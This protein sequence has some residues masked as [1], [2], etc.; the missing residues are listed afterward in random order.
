MAF[1][2]KP[3]SAPVGAIISDLDVANMSR[4][5]EADLYRAFLDWGVLVFQ[6]M[7][8]DVPEHVRLANLFGEMDDPHP[9]PDL[10]HPEVP[11]MSVLTANG[12]AAVAP[13]DPDA[14]ML[15]GTI[16]WHADRM[17]T[18]RPNR[19]SLLR[20]VVIAEEGGTTGW[21]DTARIYRTLP[22]KV[23][24]RIQGLG[25]VHSYDVAHRR[26]S[27]VKGG[28]GQFPEVVHPLI[29]VHPETDRP[30]LNISPATAKE[31]VGLPKE[32]GD[33]LLG[34][35]IDFATREEEAYV[36]HWSAGDLVAWDNMRAIH[37][38]FGHAKRFPRVMNS[39]PLKS[40]MVL[41]RLFE[42]EVEAQKAAA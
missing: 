19:G 36:H 12:G 33:E 25:I 8:L 38:A 22:Y 34:W 18:I 28:A 3:T 5:D 16:P 35:L 24:C 41:G 32:E 6:D 7:R 27:M 29:I 17:Y 14:E 21:I 4:G 13:D 11:N 2:I 37:R 31:L 23:K 30:A 9:L 10:R 39:S 1:S 20:S 15:I 26:Q 42:P 40:E